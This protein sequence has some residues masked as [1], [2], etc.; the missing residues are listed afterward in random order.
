MVSVV[1][2]GHLAWAMWGGALPGGPR[3][4]L[5]G[6][7]TIQGDACVWLQNGLLCDELPLKFVPS[8]EHVC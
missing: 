8:T 5:V 3:H 7:F 1:A 4:S 6:V 2:T